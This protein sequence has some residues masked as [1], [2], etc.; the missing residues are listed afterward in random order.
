MTAAGARRPAVSGICSR[1]LPPRSVLAWLPFVLFLVPLLWQS[2]LG[3]IF[4]P[5]LIAVIGAVGLNLLTGTAGQIS[6]GQSAFLAIG[7]Y[8]AVLIG[9][10]AH[11]PFLVVLVGSAVTGGIIALL[12]GWTASRLRGLYGVLSTLALYYIVVYV[13]S[14][15]E[16]S[17]GGESGFLLPEAK[18]FGWLVYSPLQWY[19]FLAVA[20]ALVLILYRHILGTHVG[21]A[22][23]AIRD[24]DLTASMLGINVTRYELYA[25]VLS[26]AIV[27]VAGAIQA[28]Y[29]G[30]VSSDMFTLLVAIQYFAM[31]V[32]GGRGNPLGSVVGAAVIVVLPIE[33]QNLIPA[34]ASQSSTANQ[35]DYNQILFGALLVIFLFVAPDGIVGGLSRLRFDRITS[36]SAKLRT[37]SGPGRSRPEKAGQDAMDGPDLT[38]ASAPPGAGT[39]GPAPAGSGPP[40]TGLVVTAPARPVLSVTGLSVSYRGAGSALHSVGLRVD[41]GEVVAVLGANGAGKTTMLRAVAGFTPDEPGYVTGGSVELAGR[42]LLGVPTYKRA[43]QGV[44]LVPERDKVFP[45]MTVLENLRLAVGRNSGGLDV[46]D[47]LGYFPALADKRQRPAVLLSGGERQMLAIGR[48]LLL[49]PVLMLLDETTLGLAPKVAHAVMAQVRQ[50]AEDSSTS[51]LLV[52]Q[53]AALALDVADRYYILE[54]GRISDSRVSTSDDALAA[55][56]ATYLGIPA[57]P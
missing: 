35:A 28:Y 52:E 43:R 12:I 29:L 7:A 41:A 39:P 19:V 51:V 17:A 18:V 57:G 46:D 16:T 8:T 27:S 55:L 56:E 32:I 14:Q 49:R 10:K 42:P 24:R 44:V 15:Y 25:W 2:Q 22:W 37:L 47:V 50:V 34:L 20:A 6:L 40:S 11:L 23:E 9:I 5:L 4:D 26:G 54:S 48:A 38:A 13:A 30:A 3:I 31:I 53:N 21:R 45:A 36:L 1:W 33:L